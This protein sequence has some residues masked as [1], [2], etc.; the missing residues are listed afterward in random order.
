MLAPKCKLAPLEMSMP[1]IPVMPAS[2][3]SRGFQRGFVIALVLT[4]VLAVIVWR[5]PYIG[6][7][8]DAALY[9]AF[10]LEQMTPGVFAGDL[11]FTDGVQAR[12]TTF[13]AAQAWFVRLLGVST[14]GW[15]LTILGLSSFFLG[16]F[17][18]ASALV[19]RYVAAW[20][21][22]CVACLTRFYGGTA[23]GTGVLGVGEPF[24]T[25][26]PLAE[27][28]VLMGLAAL[29]SRRVWF[30]F[31]LLVAALA[32]HPLMGVAGVGVA[33]VYEGA[34]YF[35]GQLMA[36]RKMALAIVCVCVLGLALAVAFSPRY[37]AE[38]WRW[39]IAANGWFALPSR[40]SWMAY[41]MIGVT[42]HVLWIGAQHPSLSNRHACLA[43]AA[44]AM[45]GVCAA[46]LLGDFGQLVWIVSAQ[47]WRALWLLHVVSL[48]V[49]PLTAMVLWEQGLWARV[50]LVCFAAI[51]ALPVGLSSIVWWAI[52]AMM[53]WLQSREIVLA[54]RHIGAVLLLTSTAATSLL[55]ADIYQT[56]VS[57][58]GSITHT[59]A[60]A[61][62]VFASRGM[63]LLL[64]LVALWY[65][66]NALP[67]LLPAIAVA[68]TVLLAIGLSV[69][70]RRGV[71]ELR[72][73]A[74]VGLDA[75][76]NGAVWWEGAPSAA[77]W[78]VLRR[79]AYVD[80]AHFT[81]VLF[82]RE[83]AS[84]LHERV[85]SI[86]KARLA[87]RACSPDPLH[88]CDDWRFS[89]ETL[90]R[91]KD[92]PASL[93]TRRVVVEGT[94]TFQTSRDAQY[95]LTYCSSLAGVP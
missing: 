47:P 88:L 9:L 35:N 20:S 30:A 22:V 90:C 66:W 54:K 29:I 71:W 44:V 83:Y 79:P 39:T 56:W 14:S 31:T 95:F 68:V 5:R 37:D 52:A 33:I 74:D 11:L 27:G 85:L 38:W 67:R 69:A 19:N 80:N 48:V 3:S 8:H 13:A 46:L 78:L 51:Y 94:P 4:A 25:P 36:R 17:L 28:L 49:L 6:Y 61:T 70:D 7:Q 62:A 65:G 60:L 87:A 57:L 63:P 84:K 10:A 50:A 92:A 12:L 24:A 77:T 32:A 93:L 72:L 75:V 18:F 86:E 1:P 55:V 26:R 23:T 91:S 76:P 82:G 42:C 59:L 45:A 16:V 73:E 21:V 53:L 40:W 43:V 2:G 41:A 64:T 89:L 58:A 15:V 81:N 34:R